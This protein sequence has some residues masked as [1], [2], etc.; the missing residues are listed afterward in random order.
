MT[1]IEKAPVFYNL[2]NGIEDA[3]RMLTQ[4]EA[5][6][7]NFVRIQSTW[8]EQ[9]R[10]GDILADL[11]YKFVACCRILGIAVVVDRSQRKEYPRAIYQGLPWI[12]YAMNRYWYGSEHPVKVKGQDATRYFCE[13]YGSLPKEALAK[14]RYFRR[15]TGAG[16]V[17]LLGAS[18]DERTKYDGDYNTYDKMLCNVL[19]SEKS[20]H[21]EDL[22][23]MRKGDKR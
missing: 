4:R 3:A 12:E 7:F 22:L 23:K 16:K 13:Q 10:W 1:D 18:W 2:T 14:L 19:A 5:S 20:T 17:G 9:H 11:D 15:F 8:C 21:L 6:S